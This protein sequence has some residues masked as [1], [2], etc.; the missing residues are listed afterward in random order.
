MDSTGDTEGTNTATIPRAGGNDGIPSN[1]TAVV[2]ILGILTFILVVALVVMIWINFRRKRRQADVEGL[3]TVRYIRPLQESGAV[4]IS[5]QPH[6]LLVTES[7]EPLSFSAQESDT[8]QDS[9][10]LRTASSNSILKMAEPQELHHGMN[11]NLPPCTLC[12]LTFISTF[13]IFFSR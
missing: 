13:I 6:Q 11:L 10:L 2:V 3:P 9:G 7:T 1:I 12:E 5:D 4:S 8:V